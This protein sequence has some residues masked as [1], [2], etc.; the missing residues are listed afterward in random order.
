MSSTSELEGL[1][2]RPRRIRLTTAATRPEYRST[3]RSQAPI[4][5]ATRARTISGSSTGKS[6]REHAGA[7]FYSRAA[8]ELSAPSFFTGNGHGAARLLLGEH[9]HHAVALELR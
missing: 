9:H 6:G 8:R 7:G 3:K 2:P 5:P 4:S 1:I